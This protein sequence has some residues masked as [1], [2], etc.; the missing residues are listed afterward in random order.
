M[1]AEKCGLCGKDA[2]GYA[3]IGNTRYCHEGDD[4]TCFQRAAWGPMGSD[5]A[6]RLDRAWHMAL[7]E[8]P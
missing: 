2:E 7:G 1:T 5:P 4:P 6:E 3:R 8:A